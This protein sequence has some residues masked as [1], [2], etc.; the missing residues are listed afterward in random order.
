MDDEHPKEDT[1]EEA[2]LNLTGR[3]QDYTSAATTIKKLIA[4][5]PSQ[6]TVF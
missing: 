5:G 6:D 1:L 2:L 4:P 3:L